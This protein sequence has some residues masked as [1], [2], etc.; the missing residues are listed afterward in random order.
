MTTG[1]QTATAATAT[2]LDLAGQLFADAREGIAGSDSFAAHLD[3]ASAALE[4]DRA[5]GGD[6]GA[7]EAFARGM[8]LMRGSGAVDPWLFGGAAQAGWTA[9]HLS[10]FHGGQA[11]GLATVDK[12]ALRWIRQYPAERNVD[13]PMG[14]LGLGVYGLAHPS[15]DARRT[16]TGAVLDALDDRLERDEHGRFL[17]STPAVSTLVGPVVTQRD[18]GV[19]H[20]NAGLVSYLASVAMS[21]LDLH[22]RAQAMLSDTVEWLLRQRSDVDGSVFPQ[23]VEHRYV[24]ARS[25]WCYGDPG[26]ALAL[27]VAAEAT[28]STEIAAVAAETARTAIEREH[29][30]ARVVDAC[31]CHGAAGL[32]WFARRVRD[33][34]GLPEAEDYARH[35][36]D[37]IREERAAGPLHYLAHDGM[38]RDHSF[39]EG[40]LGVALALLHL[41]TG[42]PPLWEERLLAVPVGARRS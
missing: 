25:A 21:D 33:D 30:R 41:A 14:L 20:G 24:P 27:L 31:L 11:T 42:A 15:E 29:A 16:L 4:F 17:R 22:D 36:L 28:G 12:I 19:A 3:L 2:A 8:A 32:C 34:F 37:R 40:D 26:I 6:H 1:P 10:G 7:R 9:I 39:L 5:L 35:W 13:L 23:S 38:R 18:T